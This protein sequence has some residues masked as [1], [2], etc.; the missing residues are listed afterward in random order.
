MF[1]NIKGTV[2]DIRQRRNKMSLMLNVQLSSFCNYRIEPNAKNITSLMEKVNLLGIKEFLPNITTGQN[3]DL[4][5]GT[6][7]TV[8]NLGF[9][10]SDTTGQIVCQNNRID[11]MFNYNAENQC[12]LNESLDELK[13]IIVIILNEFEILSNRLA[14][15]INILS[16][17][18]EGDL[19]ETN[20]GRSIVS[21]LDFYRDKDLKEWST[22]ENVR[23]P[24]NICGQ[25]EILNVITELSK[26]TSNP[27]DEN[28]ILCHMD[29]NTIPENTGY[30]F[31]YD[32]MGCFVEQVKD[33]SG[34][35]K[36]NFEELSNHVR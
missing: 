29:I 36:L 19:K 15:N 23:Y 2:C 30:R 4:I 7:E 33:I 3:I 6:L 20:F 31:N 13:S 27:G 32:K 21:T 9:V 17:P 14:V 34:S 10:T 24:I 35:I 26:V 5:K 25:E 8:S 22:R 16:D 11:C 12:D 18:Y 1:Y 28:R